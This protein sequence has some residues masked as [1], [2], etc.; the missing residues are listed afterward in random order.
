M[1]GKNLMLT[2][3][4][5]NGLIVSTYFPAD[6]PNLLKNYCNVVPDLLPVAASTTE[7]TVSLMK[8]I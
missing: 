1:L 7:L 8:A 6:E 2:S 3:N 5:A 4:V